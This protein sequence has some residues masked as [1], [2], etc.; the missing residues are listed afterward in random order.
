MIPNR[1]AVG[2][3]TIGWVVIAG[4]TKPA[5][6]V[7]VEVGKSLDLESVPAFRRADLDSDE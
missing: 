4:R 3:M 2:E 6:G 5:C 7:S 1:K